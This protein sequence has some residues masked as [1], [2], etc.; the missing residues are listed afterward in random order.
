[1][2][3]PPTGAA[4][5]LEEGP[6]GA[7]LD[8][9]SR[10]QELGFLG[11]GPVAPHIER[12]LDAL[13]LL[14]ALPPG[15]RPPYPGGTTVRRI[16]DLGSGGGL[17][18]LPLALAM[19]DSEWVLLDGS[20]TRTRFLAEAVDRLALAHR[21]RVVA[22]RAEE[23]GHAGELRGTFDGVVA[24]SF[25]PPAVTA[26][27]AAPLLRLGGRLV[28]A[29]PPGGAA[30]RWPPAGLAPLGLLA[31]GTVT[32]PTAFQILEKVGP[33][34]DRYPRRTGVPGKRPLF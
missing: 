3:G 5:R 15:D 34:P 4:H 19:E 1:M 23:A 6:Y 16:L 17:P 21:V 20:T 30:D 8:V 13:P 7:L 32:E 31:L 18:G 26:E 22:A 24:R 28:V 10:S 29:E 12:A 33:C 9:L 14:A 25:G 27:C 11:P 2:A